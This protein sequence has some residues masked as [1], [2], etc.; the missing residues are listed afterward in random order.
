MKR[1]TIFAVVLLLTQLACNMPVPTPDPTQTPIP[2]A[3]LAPTQTPIPTSTPPFTPE[4]L[5]MGTHRYW[6]ET[7]EAGCEATEDSK[8]AEY[9]EKTHIFSADLAVVEYGGR[10]YPRTGFHRYQSINQSD[11]PLVLIYS[12]IGFD[13]EIYRPGE[14]TETTPACLIF[15]FRLAD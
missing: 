5:N 11:K 7:I 6:R 12:E 14:D 1:F 8:G 9:T 15:R 13:L 3:T 4:E 10:E 2:T